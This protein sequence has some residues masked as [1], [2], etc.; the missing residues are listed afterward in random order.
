[1]TGAGMMDCKAALKEAEGDYDKA[2]DIIREK[3]KLVADKRADRTATE[4][5]VVYKVDGTKG[6]MLCLA[7]E[8]DFVAKN[9]EFGASAGAI[10][11]VAV[12]NDCADLDA[13][14]A[15]VGDVVTEKS[16]QTGEKVELP[17][18]A[19]VEA[20]FIDAYVHTNK[21][22]GSMVGFS[23][24]IPA[25]VAHDVCMQATAMAPVSIDESDVPA[26]VLEKE[27]EIGRE[28]ARQ[29]GKP[30]AMLDKIAEGKL[31]KYIKE[32]TLVNQPLVKN[33]KVSVGQ[34]IAEA[35]KEAK[36]VAYKRF[37]LND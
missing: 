16:G 12:K 10:L 26:A 21:K 35:D 19:R 9:D 8:T 6:Y 29:E 20:P 28:Q 14:M 27:R 1:M 7:C 4:G 34:F 37:S 17:F 15:L 33:P 31:A 5:V 3:G 36:I 24:A 25:E 13:L 18:Y 23:K 2:K 11:E 22:L 30:E 32:N